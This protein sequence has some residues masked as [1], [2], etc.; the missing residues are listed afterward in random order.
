MTI[1]APRFLLL[2]TGQLQGFQQVV[3]IYINETKCRLHYM[4]KQ[5]VQLI[6]AH[7]ADRNKPVWYNDKKNKTKGIIDFTS[8]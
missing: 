1:S 3:K 5:Q 4:A 6:Y 7:S 2:W 8:C